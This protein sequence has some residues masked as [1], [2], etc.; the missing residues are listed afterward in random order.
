MDN[1]TNNPADN[2]PEDFFDFDGDRMHGGEEDWWD[3]QTSCHSEED[4]E[5]DIYPRDHEDPYPEF[6]E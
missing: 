3:Y 4:Y 1:T 2:T 5:A 6:D